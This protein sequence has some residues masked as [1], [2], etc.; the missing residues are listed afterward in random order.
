MYHSITK[1][2]SLVDETSDM[3]VIHN[4]LMQN[5]LLCRSNTSFY[6]SSKYS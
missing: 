2:S 1:I 6:F 4:N 3:Q 5:T